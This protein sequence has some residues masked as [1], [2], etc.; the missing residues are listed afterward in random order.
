MIECANGLWV[1]PKGV[2]IPSFANASEIAMPFVLPRYV[3]EDAE[4]DSAFQHIT[5][6]AEKKKVFDI[7]TNV[8]DLLESWRIHESWHTWAEFHGKRVC[9]ETIDP[10]DEFLHLL[11]SEQQVREELRRRRIS[12][13]LSEGE[14]G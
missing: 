2:D 7:S 13:Y 3:I 9:V 8:A 10:S 14:R 12:S 6:R 5:C 1:L 4:P 11:S